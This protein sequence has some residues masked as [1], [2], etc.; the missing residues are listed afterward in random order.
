MC[1]LF[2]SQS[3]SDHVPSISSREMKKRFKR[4]FVRPIMSNYVNAILLTKSKELSKCILLR[5]DCRY[6]PAC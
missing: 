4:Y 5:L 6:L 2:L 1:N 3:L